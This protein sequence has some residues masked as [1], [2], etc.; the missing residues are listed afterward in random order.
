MKINYQELAVRLSNA[1]FGVYGFG[2][3][4][5]HSG[6]VTDVLATLVEGTEEELQSL[7]KTLYAKRMG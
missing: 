1:G 3:F 5:L 7:Y 2:N 6:E 4:D